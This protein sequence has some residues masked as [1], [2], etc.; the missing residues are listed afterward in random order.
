MHRILIWSFHRV[1][2]CYEKSEPPLRTTVQVLLSLIR[3]GACNCFCIHRMQTLCMAYNSGAWYAILMHD[4]HAKCTLC[5]HEMTRI[6]LII[7]HVPYRPFI[8]IL[9]EKKRFIAKAPQRKLCISLWKLCTLL[10]DS[11]GYH[12]LIERK[13]KTPIPAT[14]HFP[15]MQ[16]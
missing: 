4:M 13:K 9:R 8:L 2:V 15:C 1:R 5:M 3:V 16:E 7:V 14:V 10:F 6:R 12:K 11:G